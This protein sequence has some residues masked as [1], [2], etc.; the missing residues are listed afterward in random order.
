MTFE[1]YKSELMKGDPYITQ[2]YDRGDGYCLIIKRLMFHWTML[3]SEIG[4]FCSYDDRWCYQTEA[5]AIKAAE[6]WLAEKTVEPEGW[7]RHHKTARRRTDGDPEREYIE[8]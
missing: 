6:D 1:E 5:G 2:M 7:H 4:D 3:V 8:T